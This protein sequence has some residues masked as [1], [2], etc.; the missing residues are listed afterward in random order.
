METRIKERLIGAIALVAIVVIVVPELLTGP[1]TRSPPP[2]MPSSDPVRTVSI[3]LSA[4]ERGAIAR[5]PAVVATAEP[6]A[7]VPPASSPRPATPPATAAAEP[8]ATSAPATPA[9]PRTAT[10]VESGAAPRPTVPAAGSAGWVVQLGSF[11]SR[12]NADGLVKALRAN[13]YRAFVSEFHGSGRVLYRVR[14]GPEQDRARAESLA[15]R[16]AHEGHR[17]SIAPEP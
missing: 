14:V 8:A 5:T 16:L 4:A 12:D 3:D 9:A 7:G 1:P 13:G 11:A 15:T 6:A 2:A 17:G 10:T